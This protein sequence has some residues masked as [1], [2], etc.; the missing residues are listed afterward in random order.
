MLEASLALRILRILCAPYSHGTRWFKF[1]VIRS[2]LFPLPIQI[3]TT[4]GLP[5]FFMILHNEDMK[6]IAV[7]QQL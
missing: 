1:F 6:Y 2:D 3:S 5:E 4:E 7:I